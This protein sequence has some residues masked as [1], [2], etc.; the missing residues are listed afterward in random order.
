MICYVQTALRG[1][2]GYSELFQ[3]SKMKR[4]AKIVNNFNKSLR[5]SCVIGI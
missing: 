4:V 5:F 1:A 2:D 3:T